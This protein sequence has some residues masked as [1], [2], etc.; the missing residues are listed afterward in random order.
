M[1]RKVKRELQSIEKA[2]SSLAYHTRNLS[3][4][5][6]DDAGVIERM[7]QFIVALHYMTEILKSKMDL[8]TLVDKT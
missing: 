7:R 5:V 6:D 3:L 4:W 1:D 2:I 8:K